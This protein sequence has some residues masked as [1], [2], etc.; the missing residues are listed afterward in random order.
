[1]SNNNQLHFVYVLVLQLWDVR[2]P[3]Q[4]ELRLP[5]HT[6]GA[7]R[8][9]AWCTEADEQGRHLLASGGSA[10]LIKLWDVDA[11]L[12]GLAEKAERNEGKNCST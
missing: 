5:A 10:G 11:A 3:A 7:I 12:A 2:S 9:I 8:A 6:N 1:M 4:P